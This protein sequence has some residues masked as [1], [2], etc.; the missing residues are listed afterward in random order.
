LLQHQLPWSACAQ[1]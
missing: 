1:N